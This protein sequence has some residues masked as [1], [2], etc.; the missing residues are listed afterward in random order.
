MNY[1]V[2]ET[3][4]IYHPNNLI[5]N[6]L[7]YKLVWYYESKDHMHYD[8]V[9]QY[10]LGNL[11]SIICCMQYPFPFPET[12][13]FPILKRYIIPIFSVTQ[14]SCTLDQPLHH[15]AL[16]IVITPVHLLV[17]LKYLIN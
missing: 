16:M 14:D 4:K 12:L 8:L 13:I 3:L 2:L 11:N 7:Q 6:L 10:H 15:H 9:V 5:L 17:K 1:I